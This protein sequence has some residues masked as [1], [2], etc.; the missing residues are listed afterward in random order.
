M[1]LTGTDIA[2]DFGATHPD[3]KRALQRW[4]ALIRD[5]RFRNI[6]DLRKTFGAVDPVGDYTVFNMRGN[7]YRLI[8]VINYKEQICIIDDVMT[9]KAYDRWRPDL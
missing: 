5:N 7:N 9:H 8:A 4:I 6:L 3:A 1:T 2:D